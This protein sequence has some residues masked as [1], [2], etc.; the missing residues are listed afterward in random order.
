ML[1]ENMGRHK[2]ARVHPT[3]KPLAVIKWAISVAEKSGGKVETILDPFMGSGTTLVAAKLL[4]KRAVGIEVSEQY[5]GSAVNRLRQGV[6][7]FTH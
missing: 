4:G 6:L 1:Q 2:E 3:Q 5:C 7:P